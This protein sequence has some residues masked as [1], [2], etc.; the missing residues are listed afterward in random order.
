[1]PLEDSK[2]ERHFAIVT[3]VVDD[4]L[5]EKLRGAVYFKSDTLTGKTEYPEPAEPSFPLAGGK[6]EGFFWVPQVG[7]QIEIEIDSADEHANPKY[8]RMLYSSEDDIPEEFK[9]NYPYR[10]GWR[11][12]VGHVLVFDN[13]EDALL[14][15][16]MHK[17]GTGFEWDKDGNEIKTIIKDLKETIKGAVIRE[18]TKEVKETFKAEVT[19]EYAAKVMEKYKNDLVLDVQGA[20][21]AM[22]KK[23][24]SLEATGKATVKSKDKASIQGQG[25]TD[26]GSGAS[27]TNI[28]G[29]LVNLGG[30]GLPVAKVGS[31]VIGIG[32]LGAPVVSTIVDG[33]PTVTTA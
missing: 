13:K 20:I 16:L 23:E 31:Q 28:L 33:S 30:G 8:V 32:N 5:K 12:R 29:Q 14:V 4:K 1:M 19:R 18:V 24:L 7:D 26:V 9:T 11:T 15:K 27:V 22:I 2:I 17:I 10:M 3:K 6:G 21:K 25:G